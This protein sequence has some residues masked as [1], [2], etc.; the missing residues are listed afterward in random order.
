MSKQKD[1]SKI[2]KILC[3]TCGSDCIVFHDPLNKEYICS[4]CLTDEER[5]YKHSGCDS[6]PI[7][8]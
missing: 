3:T 2:N 5:E 4:D 1:R 6:E 7:E 8:E